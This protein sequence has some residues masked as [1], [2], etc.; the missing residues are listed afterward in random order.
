MRARVD[1]FTDE[2]WGGVQIKSYPL[3]NIS[4]V[5]NHA[6][7]CGPEFASI[8]EGKVE[9]FSFTVIEYKP[10]VIMI[11]YRKAGKNKFAKEKWNV[12]FDL[13]LGK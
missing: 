2:S 7:L 9:S 8:A 10:V 13:K 3:C 12:Y 6:T 4:V 5:D 11:V 1:R